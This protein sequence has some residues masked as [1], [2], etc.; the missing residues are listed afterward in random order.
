MFF[1]KVTVFG[2]RK[3]DGQPRG[4]PHRRPTW[5]ITPLYPQSDKRRG[6]TPRTSGSGSP[7]RSAE[8]ATS[9]SPVPESGA[10]PL[11]PRSTAPARSAASTGPSS[12]RRARGGAP[13]PG[14]RRA[15]PHPAGAWCCASR[16]TRSRRSGILHDVSGGGLVDAVPRARCPFR[17]TERP[18][19]RPS[20]R[21][22]GRPRRGPPDAPAA[23]GRRRARA[24]PSSPWRRMLTAVQGGHQAVLMAPTEV[25]AEQHPVGRA[26]GCSTG[27]PC[28][29]PTPALSLFGRPA[30]RRRAAHQPSPAPRTGA[31][32]L[33]P[34]ADGTVD[35]VVG[36]HALLQEGVAVPVAR[37]S[38]S[39]TSSTASASSSG[40]PSR[41]KGATAPCP[42]CW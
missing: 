22:P 17:L 26:A 5:Q 2:G 41:T 34:M 11:R 42:T 21:S 13:A 32:S 3:H 39:S 7:R 4:R 12:M 25:L 15:V 36:T 9:S 30:A 28:P 1:G 23:A 24:R 40:P 27:S 19:R 37:A 18:G 38:W 6:C 31:G 29:S 16:P 20:T 10:R 33:R 35:L 14:V 8:P